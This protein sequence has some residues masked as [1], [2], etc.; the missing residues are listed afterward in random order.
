[1]EHYD[2]FGYRDSRAAPRRQVAASLEDPSS[3]LSA[4]LLPLPLILLLP[5]LLPLVVSAGLT[6]CSVFFASLLDLSAAK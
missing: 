6:N 4:F 5:L 3:L 1:M 2:P